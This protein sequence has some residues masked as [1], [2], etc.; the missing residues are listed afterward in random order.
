VRRLQRHD[1]TPPIALS[2]EELH[3]LSGLVAQRDEGGTGE[4]GQREPVGGCPTEGDQPEA[5]AEPAVARR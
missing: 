3:A 5:E 4:L 2:H 1:A